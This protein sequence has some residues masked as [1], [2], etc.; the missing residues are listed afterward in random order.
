[1]HAAIVARDNE[2]IIETQPILVPAVIRQLEQ[3]GRMIT[4]DVRPCHDTHFS[5]FF[6]CI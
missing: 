2:K 1:M 3:S 6:H 4:G 5:Y